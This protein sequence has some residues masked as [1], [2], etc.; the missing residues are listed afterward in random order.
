MLAVDQAWNID[1]FELWIRKLDPQKRNFK[2]FWSS[3]SKQGFKGP[4]TSLYSKN[5]Q[6]RSIFGRNMFDFGIL[7]GSFGDDQG[8]FCPG[9]IQLGK[10][11]LYKCSRNRFF[12]N[13]CT[14]CSLKRRIRWSGSGPKVDF[15]KIS[16]LA[17]PARTGLVV[18][19]KPL[20]VTQRR[21]P[22]LHVVTDFSIFK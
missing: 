16:V 18:S 17:R 19:Q 6:Q 14:V 8:M 13:R 9:M 4:R 7:W 20:Y 3:W 21:G 1:S 5:Y 15:D 2:I 22:A 12:E 11:D 10:I